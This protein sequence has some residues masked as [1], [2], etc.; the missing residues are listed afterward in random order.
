MALNRYNG[1]KR[2]VAFL[3]NLLTTG[4]LFCGF[5]SIIQSLEGDF[6]FAVW[7]VV[8]AGLFDFLD[9]R[10][11]RMTGTQSDFGIEYDSLADL[12][13]FCMAPA[14]MAFSW[15]VS[16]FGK[17]G[18]A[19]CFMYFACGALRLAR[20]NVQSGDVEKVD[21]QGLP[22]PSAAGTMVSYVLFHNY[23]F[24]AQPSPPRD[25]FMLGMTV[26]IALLMVSD[27]RYRSAKKLQKRASFIHL[28]G[29]VTAFFIIVARPEIALFL[30]GVIY[31]SIGLIGRIKDF[32]NR[33]F[34]AVAK[35]DQPI[36]A[37]DKPPRSRFRRRRGRRPQ[38]D[39]R[40]RNHQ[41]ATSE[42]SEARPAPSGNIVKIQNRD[43]D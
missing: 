38:W 8:L 28:V 11:A 19:A 12:T 9:G 41:P 1:M 4:N 43:Y 36:A 31:I 34:A 7:L 32:Q 5:F 10:V 13:T 33:G 21:F 30:V 16:G 37:T 14:V 18:I 39:D 26:V 23:F 29:V 42:S 6:T 25:F 35:D 15:G 22:T 3:P 2:G 17:F 20:F 40:N 24:G 27:I